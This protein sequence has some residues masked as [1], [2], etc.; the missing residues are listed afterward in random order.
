M[1]AASAA[2]PNIEIKIMSTKSTTNMAISP[3]EA[4]ADITAT[5]RM[6]ALVRNLALLFDIRFPSLAGTPPMLFFRF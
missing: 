2:F 6:G 4:V 3:M 1:A 5:C